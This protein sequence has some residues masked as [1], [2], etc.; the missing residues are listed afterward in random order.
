[1]TLLDLLQAEEQS[2]SQY[3]NLQLHTL[4]LR[5]EPVPPS[6]VEVEYST[7]V[8]WGAWL[9]WREDPGHER[10]PRRDG[11]GQQGDGLLAQAAIQKMG[12][13]ETQR[14]S[15]P[16]EEPCIIVARSRK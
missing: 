2:E 12:Q 14:E 3:V 1:M 9:P 7:L 15:R 16:L 11:D 8:S 5:E 13:V 10:V 6:Q 4:P